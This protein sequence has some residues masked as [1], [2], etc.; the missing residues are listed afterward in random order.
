MV[1]R[2][3]LPMNGEPNSPRSMHRRLTAGNVLSIAINASLVAAAVWYRPLAHLGL[4][5]FDARHGAWADFVAVAVLLGLA[6]TVYTF[7][8]RREKTR[9]EMTALRAD[10]VSGRLKR[11]SLAKRCT[12]LLLALALV[13]GGSLMGPPGKGLLVVG[14]P[15]FL[16]LA[17]SE[18]TV[19]LH[20]G[21]ALL[22]DPHDE[23]L[24]FF[25]ARTLQVGYV[26][27]ILSLAALYVVSLF[28]TR[29]L[30]MLVAVVLAVSLLVPAFAYRRLDRL[31]G[32]NE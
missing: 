7:V 23:L 5:D 3:E 11:M 30:G 9:A 21:D 8:V 31:A 2:T 15:L 12:A 27:A 19:V 10:I 16:L 1:P 6:K 22:P 29:H 26:T 14:V 24:M 18:V 28:G 32:P 20:P 13:V 17:A 25:K 4:A